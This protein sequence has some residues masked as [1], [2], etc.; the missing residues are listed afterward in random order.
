MYLKFNN[1]CHKDAECHSSTMEESRM[2]Q[3]ITYP[4]CRLLILEALQEDDD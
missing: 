3:W 2:G 1:S 4:Q